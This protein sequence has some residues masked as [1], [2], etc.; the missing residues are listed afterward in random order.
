MHVSLL[1]TGFYRS[2]CGYFSLDGPEDTAGFAVPTYCHLCGISQHQLDSGL[3]AAVIAPIY[4][5]ALNQM[6]NGLSLLSG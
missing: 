1:S 5:H 4:V 6:L 2:S 3:G